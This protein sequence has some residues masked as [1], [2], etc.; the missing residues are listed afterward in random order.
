MT[1][2][3]VDLGAIVRKLREDELLD[4]M[5]EIVGFLKPDL[6]VDELENCLEAGLTMSEVQVMYEE[7]LTDVKK[8]YMGT[9]CTLYFAC[10]SAEFLVFTYGNGDD[11][12][13]KTVGKKVQEDT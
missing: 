5:P 11:W 9:A 7:Y 8:D 12:Q 1:I 13:Y 2:K 6:V 4:S 10:G 3:M